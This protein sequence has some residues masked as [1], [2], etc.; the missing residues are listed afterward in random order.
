VVER[1]PDE[2]VHGGV[3][4][5]ECFAA[6][7]LDVEDAGEESSGLGYD[8]SAGLEEEVSGFVGQAFGEGGGVFFYLLCGVEGGVT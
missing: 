6:V 3:G 2:I 1:W 4:D 7:F 5:D 8:E